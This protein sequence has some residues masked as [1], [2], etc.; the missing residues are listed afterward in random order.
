MDTTETTNYTP[1]IDRA[2]NFGPLTTTFTPP[3]SCSSTAFWR[4]DGDPHIFDT[5]DSGVAL[6]N[7]DCYPDGWDNEA[8]TRSL[9]Y[10]SPGNVCPHAWTTACEV[11]IG[12][13]PAGR[14]AF[15]CCPRFVFFR[16]HAI[17][18]KPSN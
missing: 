15:L 10:F 1:R 7:S 9:G 3:S 8:E 11:D 18:N 2:T 13:R 6:V 17:G 12:V 4:D 16:C 5:C 14:S